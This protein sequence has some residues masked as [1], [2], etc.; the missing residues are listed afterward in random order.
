MECADNLWLWPIRGFEI[1]A[2]PN[3]QR[4]GAPLSNSTTNNCTRNPARTWKIYMV[5]GFD[6]EVVD[7]KFGCRCSIYFSSA[8]KATKKVPA[9]VLQL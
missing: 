9:M 5:P 6:I 2:S 7:S 8:E 3:M 1:T 4:D